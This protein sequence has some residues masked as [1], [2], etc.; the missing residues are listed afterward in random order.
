MKAVKIIYIGQESCGVCQ[1]VYPRIQQFAQEMAISIERIEVNQYPEVASLYEVLTVPAIIVKVG[2]K[3]FA[4][5]ARFIDLEL[6]EKQLQQAQLLAEMEEG[7][8]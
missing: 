7:T 4:R 3:E 1:A 6:L 5:Q 8:E 2:E